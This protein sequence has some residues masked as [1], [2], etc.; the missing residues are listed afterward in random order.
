MCKNIAIIPARGGSK[1]IPKKNI[2]NFCGK[3][4]IAYSIE[5]A[6]KSNIFDEI[7]VSTDSGEIADIARSY[8]AS[9]PFYR[10]K[11]ASN[12]FATTSDV[13]MEV[14]GEYKKAG[15]NFEY[16]FCIYPTAPFITSE[17]IIDAETLMKDKKPN[18]IVTVVEFSYPPQRSYVVTED[19][20][21]KYRYE[22]YINSRSQD[23][24]KWYHDV[25]QLYVYNVGNFCA[26]NGQ[27]RERIMPI[28]VSPLVAQD[29][30]TENDWILAEEKY[31][32]INKIGK[33]AS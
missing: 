11:E 3:P 26:N 8:G 28:M 29:I 17:L 9:V 32:L 27:I 21:I 30:D 14:L 1:R 6:I 12:D 16:A 23:L 5:A 19:G 20:M 33:G 2:K 13:I 22:Q 10:S 4:I 18:E 7:M 24:E 25:G 31:K 15:K